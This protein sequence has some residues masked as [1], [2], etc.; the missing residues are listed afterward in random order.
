[1]DRDRRRGSGSSNLDHQRP[2]AARRPNI[3]DVRRQLGI[4]IESAAITQNDDDDVNDNDKDNDDDEDEVVVVQKTVN[5]FEAVD[6]RVQQANKDGTMIL[7][8][9]E[10]EEEDNDDDEDHDDDDDEPV[11]NA[12]DLIGRRVCKQF[13]KEWFYGSV[14]HLVEVVGGDDDD[15]ENNN[16]N[17]ENNSNIF[18]HVDY[19]DGDSED[20]SYLDLQPCLDEWFKTNRRSKD[21][22]WK[23]IQRYIKRSESEAKEKTKTKTKTKK[24]KKRKTSS[25]L[26][27]TTGKKLRQPT[28]NDLAAATKSTSSFT[29]RQVKKEKTNSA[30]EGTSSSSSTT[31]ATY[32]GSRSRAGGIVASAASAQRATTH[33]S[34]NDTTTTTTV[35]TPPPRSQQR[36]APPQP[37]PPFDA[38]EWIEQNEDSFSS[39]DAWICDMAHWLEDKQKLSKQNGRTVLRQVLKLVR[40]QGVGYNPHW[41]SHVIFLENVRVDLENFNFEFLASLALRYEQKYGKDKGHGWLLRHPLKKLQLFQE[42]QGIQPP[43]ST[44]DLLLANPNFKSHVRM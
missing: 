16:N 44:Q 29:S 5:V 35:V 43:S 22:V 4:E 38:E 27:P 1:M 21:T 32:S 34:A 14:S 10:D 28:L 20:M 31:T 33:S 40:G 30:T 25:D 18:F 12:D 6:Q 24:N 3:D 42:Y 23:Q 9:H 11:V 41:P 8:D 13:G 36:K 37:Q 26:S 17:N 15:F 7:I 2:P 39:L 19:D